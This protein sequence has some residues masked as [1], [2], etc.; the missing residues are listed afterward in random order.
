MMQTEKRWDSLSK[1]PKSLG[2]LEELIIQLAG[3]QENPLPEIGKKLVLCYAGDHGVVKEGVSP[4]KQIV[5]AEMVKNFANGGAAISVLAKQNGAALTVI[6]TGMA[7][8]IDHPKVLQMSIAPGTG[9]MAEG[10]AMTRD[11]A[12]RAVELGF[13]LTK[14][15]IKEGVSLIATGEMGVGNT[16]SA[17]AIYAC[18]TGLKPEEITGTGAGLLP[19][20]VP[21]KAQI[22]QR[23][24]KINHP[25][26]KDPLS[27]LVAVGGFELAAMLGTMIAG[28]VYRCPIV[29]DG[30]I[31]GAAAVLAMTFHREIR[32]YLIFSHSSGEKGFQEVCRKFSIDPLVDL[33]MQ[34]GEGTGSVLIIPLIEN[35]LAC[36]HQMAT[37]EEAGVTE[38]VQ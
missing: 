35:S 20:K 14:R 3:I 19:E 37:F 16:T 31:S 11:Q 21:H 29:V 28:A 38:V 24:L 1:P 27:V 12:K 4:S 22:I 32:N 9:N 10:P 36:Y 7:N 33:K 2:K 18:M 25:D 13:Q 15:H 17:S 6:N 23:A 8:P 26:P 30:F 5:T 34:L